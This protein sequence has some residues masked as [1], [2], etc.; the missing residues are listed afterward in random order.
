[1]NRRLLLCAIP[2]VLAGTLPLR[3]AEPGFQVSARVALGA[4]QAYVEQYLANLLATLKVAAVTVEAQSGTWEAVK[5]LVTAIAT[6]IPAQAAVWYALPDGS[7]STAEKGPTGETLTD[8]E[9]FPSLFAGQNV[10]GALVVSKSTGHRSII[11]AAPVMAGGKVVAALGASVRVRLLS[12]L[13][14]AQ[15]AMPD[16][17]IFY[18]L[19]PHGRTVLHRDPDRMFEYPSELGDAS[20]KAAVSR[21]LA[22]PSGVLDYSFGGKPRQAVFNRSALTGWTFVL[23]KALA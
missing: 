20:L 8:R 14:E 18:A 11:V 22:E 17:L 3:A 21:I 7:Y 10:L 1:M 16:E 2:A 6:D 23:V 15:T 9:Y 19:D 4:Y 12:S 13:V 5:P